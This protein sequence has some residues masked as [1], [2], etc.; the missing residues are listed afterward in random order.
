MYPEGLENENASSY[1]LKRGAFS[2]QSVISGTFRACYKFSKLLL[3]PSRKLETYFY[4]K[5]RVFLGGH[6]MIEIVV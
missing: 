6:L 2:N 4:K 5:K 3:V 1:V